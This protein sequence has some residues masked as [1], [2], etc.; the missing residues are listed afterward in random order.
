MLKW[1]MAFFSYSKKRA[2]EKTSAIINYKKSISTVNRIYVTD[3]SKDELCYCIDTNTFEPV[4]YLGDP[5]TCV[6]GISDEKYNDLYRNKLCNCPVGA[7][8]KVIQGTKPLDFIEEFNEKYDGLY[9]MEEFEGTDTELENDWLF[10]IYTYIYDSNIC[11][12]YDYIDRN[13]VRQNYYKKACVNCGTCMSEL[14]KMHDRFEYIV[15]S[16]EMAKER[17]KETI[18]NQLLVEEICT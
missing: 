11:G 6:K 16:F 10:R 14:P 8:R 18:K 17:R 9:F 12:G 7:G 2:K 5:F 3:T 1:L 15:Q 4:P 13:V